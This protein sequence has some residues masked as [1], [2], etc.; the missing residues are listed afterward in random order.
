ML[1]CQALE[2]EEFWNFPTCHLKKYRG[3]ELPEF[4]ANDHLPCG[5][6]LKSQNFRKEGTKSKD[7]RTNANTLKY[8]QLKYFQLGPNLLGHLWITQEKGGVRREELFE[9]QQEKSRKLE[10]CP[11]TVLGD[12][13]GFCRK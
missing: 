4:A 10:C 3:T 1:T 7:G 5:C 6:N 2:R 11:H 13:S 8:F 12:A 9:A